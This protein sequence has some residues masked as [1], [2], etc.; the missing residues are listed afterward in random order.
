MKGHPGVI[1]DGP[2]VR[3]QLDISMASGS[4][5]QIVTDETWKIRE[6]PLSPLG[7]G[8]AFGDYG[9]ERYDPALE[10]PDWNGVAL[11]DS[12]WQPALAFEPPKVAGGGA[13][14]GAE[15]HH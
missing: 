10:L 4:P 15:P 11:D 3:A 13:D 5:L 2:L 7:R 9:G 1:H 6:S 14:G 8:T 12:G